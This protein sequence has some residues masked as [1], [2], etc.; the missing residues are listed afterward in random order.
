MSLVLFDTRQRRKLPFEPTTTPATMYLCGMT[1]KAPPHLGHARLFLVADVLR[2]YLAW[3]GIALTYV[4]NFTDMDDKIIE[5]ARDADED[6][7]AYAQRMTDAYF[8]VMDAL[9]VQRANHY[10]K[11]TESIAAI[12]RVTEGLIEQGHA[13]VVNSDVYFAVDAFATYGQLSGRVDEGVDAGRRVAIDERKRNPRDFAL[14]KAAAPDEPAWDSPWGPGRP[15][16]HIECTSM[17]L[18]LLGPQIDIH[19]G[20][21]DLIFPHHEN[22][23]AQSEA[24]TGE[25][26]FAQHWMHIGLLMSGSEKMAHSLNNYTTVAD[27]L[28]TY[29]PEALRLYL[30]SAHYRSPMVFAPEN[31]RSV[32]LGMDRLV[33]A[34]QPAP[35]AS[36]G[37]PSAD[38]L[39]ATEQARRRFAEAMDDDLNTPGAIAVLHD[40]VREINRAREPASGSVEP[41]RLVLCELAAVLGVDL[42]AAARHARSQDGGDAASFIDLLLEVRQELRATGQ[43]AVADTIR[44]RLAELGVSV[45]DRPDAPAWRRR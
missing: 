5:R 24:Y 7:L 13:Y 18:E 1:P 6:P 29:P 9:G 14:W 12:I 10:P 38:L 4:Q 31:V 32:Q 37:K 22:E 41:A 25:S 23:I 15:G 43:Y 17:V 3:R 20:G 36:P 16:W 11:V 8:Q 35:A 42:E 27:L 26:P 44:D 28:E 34:A 39:A 40:L 30:L 21:A 33:Q 2:R 45:E 19:A